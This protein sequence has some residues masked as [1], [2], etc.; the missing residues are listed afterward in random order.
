[1]K[2]YQIAWL[3]VILTCWPLNQ[4]NAQIKYKIYQTTKDGIKLLGEVNFGEIANITVAP[5]PQYPH[6]VI[7]GWTGDCEGQSLPTCYLVVDSDKT[8]GVR[9][10]TRV[11]L[12]ATPDKGSRFEGW[13]GD[14]CFGQEKT[15]E[16]VLDKESHVNAE[17]KKLPKPLWRRILGF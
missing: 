2:I 4:A 15:C 6:T 5:D 1:M 9:T 14:Y 17:F 3:F 12:T 11:T 10:G 16:F 8:F 13:S 7:L